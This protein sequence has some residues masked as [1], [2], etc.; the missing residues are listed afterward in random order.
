MLSSGDACG[1]CEDVGY[2]VCVV[3]VF[4]Q[5]ARGNDG[6]PGGAGPPVGLRLH[7]HPHHHH[8]L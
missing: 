2:E 1:L 8:L 7:H 5:G 4:D 6:L 3:S